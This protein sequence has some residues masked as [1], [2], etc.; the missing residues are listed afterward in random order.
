MRNRIT[1]DT[2]SDIDEFV[3]IVSQVPHKVLLVS[4]KGFRVNA[5]SIFGVLASMTFSELWVECEVDI[6][7]LIQKFIK[8]ESSVIDKSAPQDD[9][10]L[11]VLTY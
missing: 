9:F 1:L 10:W 4:G 11:N 6:Y 3:A 8:I 2:K 7:S 5:K